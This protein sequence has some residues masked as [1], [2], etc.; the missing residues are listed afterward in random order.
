MTSSLEQVFSKLWVLLDNEG[1]VP[2]KEFSETD[3][4]KNKDKMYA[5]ISF[6]GST[7]VCQAEV[8]ES[9]NYCIETDHRICLHLFGKSGDFSNYETLTDSCYELFYAILNDP[10]L[11]IC[12]MELSKAVQTMP[13][14]RLER[15]LEFTVRASENA[16][17]EQ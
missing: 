17:V 10:D 4:Q 11:L 2:V 13:I 9:D 14:R 6:E 5:V 3:S 12:K 1:F 16:E 8:Y 7:A 15:K